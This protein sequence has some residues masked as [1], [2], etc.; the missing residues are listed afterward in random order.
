MNSSLPSQ[1]HCRHWPGVAC[2]HLGILHNHPTMIHCEIG[3]YGKTL[4]YHL[5]SMVSTITTSSLPSEE[6]KHN[7]PT[8]NIGK[9]IT[10]S[11]LPHWG[12]FLAPHYHLTATGKKNQLSISTM[13]TITTTPLPLWEYL[14][15]PSYHRGSTH[16]H[17]TT[18]VG[19]PITTVG[20]FTTMPLPSW[21]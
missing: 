9:R 6:K 4:D 7:W 17:P 21:E 16:Y 1:C 11:L 20:I 15:P 10:T 8:P 13:G 18:I 14:L 3:H 12:Q 5:T 19:I 2:Y